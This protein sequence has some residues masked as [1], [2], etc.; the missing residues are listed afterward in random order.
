MSSQ[1]DGAGIEIPAGRCVLVNQVVK[2]VF[3]RLQTVFFLKQEFR[4][5]TLFVNGVALF[6]QQIGGAT[7]G[8]GDDFINGAAAGAVFA[9]FCPYGPIGPVR[10]QFRLLVGAVRI[11]T[12]PDTREAPA[13][14]MSA[15]R[16]KGDAIAP[17]R[18]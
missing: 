16:Q 11:R 15:Q 14:D 12:G 5:Q 4:R 6:S 8:A 2:V 13:E 1:Q 17:L 7:T 3:F 18:P 10:E 9:R